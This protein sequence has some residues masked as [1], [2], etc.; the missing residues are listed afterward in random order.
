MLRRS[1]GLYDAIP[2]ACHCINLVLLKDGIEACPAED[3]I[4]QLLEQMS[5][6][7]TYC[8]RKGHDNGLDR[9]LKQQM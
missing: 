5:A 8:K 3:P 9:T 2:C 1:S 7:V 4:K 6:V